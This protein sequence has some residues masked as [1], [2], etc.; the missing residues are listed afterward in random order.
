MVSRFL[1]CGLLLPIVLLSGCSQNSDCNSYGHGIAP[2]IKMLLYISKK[3]IKVRVACHML[4][5]FTRGRK[6]SML[7]IKKWVK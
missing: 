4:L 2:R 7:L 1:K 5:I 6:L 3:L